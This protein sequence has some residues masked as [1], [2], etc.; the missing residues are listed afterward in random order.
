[1]SSLLGEGT[2]EDLAVDGIL[3]EKTHD[4]KHGRAAVVELDFELESLL[5][6]VL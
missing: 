5:L 6:R 4:A 3:R 1:M 2:D